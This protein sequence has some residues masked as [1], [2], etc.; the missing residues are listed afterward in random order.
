[1]TSRESN[2][3]I[4]ALKIE[5]GIP[6]PKGHGRTGKGVIQ[7]LMKAMKVGDSMLMH[8]GPQCVHGQAMKYLGR[9]NYTVRKTTDGLRVWRIK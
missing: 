1:M 6:I 2:D 3:R 8:T 9:G 5:R 7:S 4:N